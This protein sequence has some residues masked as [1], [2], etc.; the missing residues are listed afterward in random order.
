LEVLT[1]SAAFAID[2]LTAFYFIRGESVPEPVVSVSLA[3]LTDP[4]EAARFVSA[5]VPLLKAEAPEV[6]ATYFCN[7]FS[8]VCVAIH[9]VMW[10]HDAVFSF[11]LEDIQV[12]AYRREARSGL[13]FWISRYQ[14][15]GRDGQDRASW[16]EQALRTFYGDKVRLL[17]ESFAA[18]AGIDVGHL[19]GQLPN[20]LSYAKDRWHNEA[21]A[22]QKQ[23]IEEDFCYMKDGIDGELFGRKR[24]PYDIKFRFVESL[25]VPGEQVRIKPACCMAYR[26][27]T[28][29]GY[30][31]TCPRID[32]AE[33]DRVKEQYLIKQHA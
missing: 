3:R 23:L 31:Y 10:R 29:H 5:Y 25:Q 12:Q 21:T 9:D 17:I 26:T 11:E 22:E 24:N 18:A 27:E 1:L 14:L 4:E 30:C 32:S 15:L 7:W 8:G 6:A 2:Q 33:R 28:D 13:S 20:R 19:W 16:R